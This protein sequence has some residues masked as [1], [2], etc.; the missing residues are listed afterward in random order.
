VDSPGTGSIE[1]AVSRILKK[2]N[3]NGLVRGSRL[4]LTKEPL[5][6]NGLK[7]GAAGTTGEQPPQGLNHRHIK[8]KQIVIFR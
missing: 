8:K 4:H 1:T 6:T 7:E 2:K 5:G 3:K